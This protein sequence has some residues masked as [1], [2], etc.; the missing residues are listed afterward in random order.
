MVQDWFGQV[1]DKTTIH[2]H[3][4]RYEIKG[5]SGSPQGSRLI[6]YGD[7]EAEQVPPLQQKGEGCMA[8]APLHS[9]QVDCLVSLVDT[10]LFTTNVL[11]G[12]TGLF[13][14]N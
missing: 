13:V 9:G 2:E 11:F 3:T 1:H 7:Q 5:G 6:V 12:P 8:T 10:A 14:T 4:C